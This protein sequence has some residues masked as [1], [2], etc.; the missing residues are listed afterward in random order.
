AD[1]EPA[2]MGGP[3]LT[4][5]LVV[6]RRAVA[7][8]PL[9]ELGLEVEALA[10]CLLDLLAERLDHSL[11]G[12]LEAVLHVAGA[13][14][15]LA[16]G[17][18]RPLGGEQRVDREALPLVRGLTGEHLGKSQLAGHLSTGAA[19]DRLVED[20]GEL[21]DVGVRMRAEEQR[22]DRQAEDAVAEKREPAIRIRS[23]L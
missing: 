18:P 16:D 5:D 4:G 22:G 21:A 15:G 7:R 6:D 8:Q 14:H 17:G 1:L 12:P 2:V 11:G 13:D 19:A 9:L 10:G 3:G 20:L 23:L